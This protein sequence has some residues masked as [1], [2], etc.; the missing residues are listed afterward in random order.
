MGLFAL[1]AHLFKKA[2]ASFYESRNGPHWR[3]V[4]KLALI[5]DGH[6]CINCK[7]TK[8][9][10]GHHIN[11]WSWFPLERF[12]LSNVAT[13]CSSCHK[14]YHKWN[15]GYRKKCTEVSFKRWVRIQKGKRERKSGRGQLVL[16]YCLSVVGIFVAWVILK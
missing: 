11:G 3:A 2:W 5:R 10:Q 14:E 15:G 8:Y 6:K 9:L 4:R 12:T 7:S 16:K 13:L 1:I